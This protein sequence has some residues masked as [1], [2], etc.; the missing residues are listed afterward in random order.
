MEANLLQLA[1]NLGTNFSIVLYQ[2]NVWE[3]IRK[4]FVEWLPTMYTNP[5]LDTFQCK[6]IYTNAKVQYMTR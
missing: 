5:K 3:F 6:C 2:S 1:R 4:M